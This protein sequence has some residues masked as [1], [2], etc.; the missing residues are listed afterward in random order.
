M[1]DVDAGGGIGDSD[2][3]NLCLM[4]EHV[5]VDADDSVL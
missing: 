2:I 1:L 4:L 5:D 3:I